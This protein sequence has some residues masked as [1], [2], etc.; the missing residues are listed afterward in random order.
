M[1]SRFKQCL[2]HFLPAV[3]FS[4]AGV[5]GGIGIY[6][7]V[8]WPG[9]LFL[10]CLLLTGA[11][12]VS[13]LLSRAIFPRGKKAEAGDD[14]ELKRLQNMVEHDFLTGVFSRR[15]I[16][17]RIGERLTA[18]GTAGALIILD[19]DNFKATNDRYGHLCGDESLKTATARLLGFFQENALIGRVGGDEFLIFTEH[20]TDRAALTRCLSRLHSLFQRSESRE[21][22]TVSLGA[23][24]FPLDGH[25]YTELFREADQ[26]LYQAKRAGKTRWCIYRQAD[27]PRA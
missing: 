25:T 27:S 2:A 1:P 8:G 4:A 11:A 19:I 3:C 15:A 6:L 20:V 13:L 12:A 24:L 9:A 10:F 16:E 14:R 5:F 7:R 23:A 22:V 21:D 18:P 17:D 26:A